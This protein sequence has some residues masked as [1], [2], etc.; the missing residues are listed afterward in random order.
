M[1]LACEQARKGLGRTAPN[2]AV[3]CVLVKAGRIVGRGYHHA[4]GMPHAEIEALRSAGS[5][6]RGADA[7]VTLEPCCHTG[8]TGPCTTA[9][10][11]AGVRSAIVGCKDPNPAVSGKGL[12][13]L[14][15]AGIRTRVGGCESECADLI[16]GFREW[17]LH[18]RPWVELK[19]AASLD[20]RIATSTGASKW[21]SSPESRLRVQDMRSRADAILVG[22]G[23]VVRDN[24]RLTCRK[25]GTPQPLRVILDHDAR[26]PVDARVVRG[27][28]SCL[29]ICSPKASPG[30]CRRLERAGAEVLALGGTRRAF[31]MRLLAA[32][33]RRGVLELL[34]EGGSEV[35]TS[36]IGAGVVNG[37]TIFYTPKLLGGDGVALV[38]TLGV[39]DPAR[40]IAVRR[41]GTEPS[42]PDIVWTG[43]F[44]KR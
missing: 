34:I 15:R 36:A 40:A 9:L 5:A 4:A 1:S 32:L 8:K 42:G 12:R 37:L 41:L 25:P 17:I 30:R 18:R 2:P 31:W 26:T 29:I 38:G 20:G 19:L 28:G 35:A 44:E 10:V 13:A 7:Y 21:L 33:G 3:G 11:D 24:P 27:R 43:V 6:A 22:V 39:R 23:T 16:R 14:A